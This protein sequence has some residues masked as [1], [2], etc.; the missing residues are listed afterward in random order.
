MAAQLPDINLAGVTV[1]QTLLY[2]G[3]SQVISTFSPERVRRLGKP[4]LRILNE[5]PVGLILTFQPSNQQVPVPAGYW[6][7]VELNPNDDTFTYLVKYILSNAGV[8]LL[9]LTFYVPGEPL[10]ATN[11]LGNSPINGAVVTPVATTANVLQGTGQI[12][13]VT[14]QDDTSSLG[15]SWDQSTILL[16][17]NRT[18][19]HGQALELAD[20]RSDG[21]TQ[22]GA[23]I[24]GGNLQVPNQ[25]NKIS[26][27][28]LGNATG[29]F[30]NSVPGVPLVP[31][32]AYS[33][34]ITSTATQ[35]PITYSVPAS[36]NA[37][38][39]IRISG[40]VLVNNGT[41]G[42]NVAVLCGYTNPGGSA[43]T[44][45][46]NLISSNT[47]VLATGS[48][49]VVNNRYAMT[50]ETVACQPGTTLTVTYRDP[51][52]TPNDAVVYII[53]QMNI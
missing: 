8:N 35:T 24:I 7:D 21:T 3:M 22:V 50:T 46:F 6:G 23:I 15:V 2:T 52:N 33:T 32:F 37:L 28:A 25:F 39:V 36:S 17:T 41:S 26:G 31:V 10:P 20:V 13:G 40:W 14:E 5:S 4:H 12:F 9:L 49:S 45:C 53:E 44:I 48:S 19:L 11:V 34:A 29:L 43:Q 27:V 18:A 47:Q 42:N 1:G 51:T 30:T 38:I 16:P